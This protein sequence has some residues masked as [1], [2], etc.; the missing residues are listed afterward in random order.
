MSGGLCISTMATRNNSG[1]PGR[2]E[3]STEFQLHASSAGKN[4]VDF[5]E[6]KLMFYASKTKDIQQQL[7]LMALIEDYRN[8]LVA[9]AWRRGSPVYFKVTK[10]S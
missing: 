4:L 10:D 1:L 9:V 5:T 6:R 8:G 2:Q 7:T 3:K